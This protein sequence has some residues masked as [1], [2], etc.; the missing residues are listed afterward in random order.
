MDKYEV[1]E[2]YFKYE[3]F[4]DVQEE[5]IDL[6][7]KNE[8]VLCLMPTGGGKSLCLLYTSPPRSGYL[9]ESEHCWLLP[10]HC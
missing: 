4:R 7:L 6:L 10:G 1:L 5:T 2:K 3:G 8:R 9:Q